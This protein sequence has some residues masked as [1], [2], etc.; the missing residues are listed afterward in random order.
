[1]LTPGGVCTADV[2]LE[3]TRCR[4]MHCKGQISVRLMESSSYKF[5]GLANQVNYC[6][7][8]I[9]NVAPPFSPRDMCGQAQHSQCSNER[10]V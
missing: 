7:S 6:R 5:D 1:M 9:K 10:A 2:C 3:N 8:A 4:T